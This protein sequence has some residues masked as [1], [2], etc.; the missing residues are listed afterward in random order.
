M[1]NELSVTR[2]LSATPDEVYEAWL[3]PRSMAEWMRPIPGGHTEVEAEPRIGGGFLIVMH[4]N[5]TRYP[6]RGEYLRLE[7]PRLLEFTWYPDG[8]PPDVQKSIVT[9]E[10]APLGHDRT[11]LTL[12]HRLLPS[13][14]LARGHQE[15]WS[16]GLD[17][18]VAWIARKHA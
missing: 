9:V 16:R 18:L 6:T 7:R 15:G 3:D 14:D 4:G 10:L 2:T 17:S 13:A 11:T 5:G 12:R 1:S 8:C